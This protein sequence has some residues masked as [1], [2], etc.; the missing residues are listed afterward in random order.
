MEQWHGL[1]QARA[2]DTPFVVIGCR[3]DLREDKATECVDGQ[4]AAVV[5]EDLDAWGYIEVQ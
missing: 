1:L 5:A 4:V 3:S 2:K